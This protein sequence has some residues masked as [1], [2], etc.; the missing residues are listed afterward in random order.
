VLST[1]TVV[2]YNTSNIKSVGNMLRK[3]GVKA[4]ITADPNEIRKAE[5]IILP[6]VGAFDAARRNLDVAQLPEVLH[7][8]VI[9]RGVPFLGICLGMQIL[10][11]GSEEGCLPGLGWVGGRVRRFS[12]ELPENSPKVPHMGWNYVCPRAS[13]HPL[14]RHMANPMRFYF[15]HS[16]HFVCESEADVAAVTSYGYDFHCAVARDNI[17]GVQFHPE[18]SHTYGM[19]LLR[20]FVEYA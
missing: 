9:E 17:W 7:E 5:K 20:N 19:Q 2:D 16:Y 4:H 10:A 13:D 6:G 18:K 3:I 11:K 8:A 15:V 1:V 12:F 14:W